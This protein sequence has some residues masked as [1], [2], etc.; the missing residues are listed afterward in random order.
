VPFGLLWIQALR[1]AEAEPDLDR[2]LVVAPII[3]QAALRATRDDISRKQ[4]IGQDYAPNDDATPFAAYFVKS[5]TRSADH[6]LARIR[7]LGEILVEIRRAIADGEL[8]LALIDGLAF[9]W[10]SRHIR[11][12]DCLRLTGRSPQAT[13]RD[14]AEAVAGGSLRATGERRRGR[15]LRART[16]VAGYARAR[17]D[18]LAGVLSSRRWDSI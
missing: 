8:S 13:T 9:A 5:I 14:L 11:A 1:V 18:R 17:R 12:G 7:G 6:V 16:E 2:F 15:Y 10:V 4:A 3:P